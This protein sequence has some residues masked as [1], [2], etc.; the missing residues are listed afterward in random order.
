MPEIA[1]MTEDGVVVNRCIFVDAVPSKG[2]IV[3]LNNHDWTVVTVRHNLDKP[4]TVQVV[5][6]GVAL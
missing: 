6:H 2:D 5:I 3:H 4:N 1:V